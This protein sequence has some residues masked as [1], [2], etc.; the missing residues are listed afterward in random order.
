MSLTTDHAELAGA[1]ANPFEEELARIRAAY[2][3]RKRDVSPDRYSETNPRALIFQRELESRILELLSA[4][5]IGPLAAARVL[6]VGCGEGRWL[7]RIVQRGAASEKL[8]G[9]DLLPERIA[10]AREACPS[11]VRLFCCNAGELPFA[12]Q[13][14]DVVSS[15][16]VF[17]SILAFNLREAVAA[18][19]LRVLRPG[20]VVLW[21]DF[22]V[23]NPAN[24]DV[25]GV[26]KAEIARLF[27]RCDIELA[28]ITVAAPLGRAVATLPFVYAALARCRIF[29]THYLGWIRKL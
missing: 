8:A 2:A 27:S 12:D 23:N 10:F 14:F 6:D 7:R 11:D 9:V 29:C 13:S 15:M 22:F 5:S 28:R 26:G 25:R 18:E 3:R 17:S 16:T 19:M 20:G 24:P 4:K 1:H 21:Y